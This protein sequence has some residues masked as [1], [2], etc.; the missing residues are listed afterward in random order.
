MAHTPDIKPLARRPHC[1]DAHQG[2]G[3]ACCCLSCVPAHCRTRCG[4][5]HAQLEGLKV[6]AT[7]DYTGIAR[8]SGRRPAKCAWSLPQVLRRPSRALAT[9]LG[10]LPHRHLPR[11]HLGQTERIVQLLRL[12]CDT[13]APQTHCERHREVNLN[14]G[15]LG[16]V[17]APLTLALA[18]SGASATDCVTQTVLCGC[19]PAV[20]CVGPS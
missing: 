5:T 15:S 3:P 10:R 20:G 2:H 1:R 11:V 19:A 7:S 8:V 18:P 17:L 14:Q 9:S 16:P 6:R 13:E 12:G 4:A